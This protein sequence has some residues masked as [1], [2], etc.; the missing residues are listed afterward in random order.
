MTE[1]TS[2]SAV[3]RFPVACIARAARMFTANGLILSP[4]TRGELHADEVLSQFA[5]TRCNFKA[6][7][8]SRSSLMIFTAPLHV[9]HFVSASN[10]FTASRLTIVNAVP[11]SEW[12]GAS[13]VSERKSRFLTVAAVDESCCTF[14]S[15]LLC[16]SC[17]SA[18]SRNSV[19][20]RTRPP[21]AMLSVGAG[22]VRPT[23]VASVVAP[24]HG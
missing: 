19:S 23:S 18:G 12:T 14:S 17:I 15:A 13:A 6:S 22:A 24:L 1:N 20:C 4:P 2:L 16:F 9:L 10:A 21:S 5:H 3:C 8:Y 7:P 11:S